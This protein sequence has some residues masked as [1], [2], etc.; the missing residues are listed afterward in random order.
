MTQKYP[1]GRK[2]PKPTRLPN[3]CISRVGVVKKRFDD[4]PNTDVGYEAYEC[5]SGQGW[6][7]RTKR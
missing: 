3:C 5:R 2:W 6:H 4:K 7:I 1:Q